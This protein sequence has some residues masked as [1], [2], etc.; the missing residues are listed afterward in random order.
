MRTANIPIPT[1][2]A[3]NVPH[4]SRPNLFGGLAPPTIQPTSAPFSS[5]NWPH[6]PISQPI[7]DPIRQETQMS[8]TLQEQEPTTRTREELHAAFGPQTPH[9]PP[10]PERR[11]H[12]WPA[13][14]RRCLRATP[15][16]TRSS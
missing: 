2:H 12:H 13:T 6:A 14:T 8:A 9:P 10:R 11:R 15:A 5:R 3:A 1:I 16:T 7:P 4:H